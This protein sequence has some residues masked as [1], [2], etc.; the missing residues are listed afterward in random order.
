MRIRFMT[1]T[2]LVALATATASGA[3]AAPA[4]PMPAPMATMPGVYVQVYGGAALAGTWTYG[5]PDPYP[6]GVDD[7]ALGSAFGA[8]VG[9]PV[10]P[11][12][13]SIE[14]DFFHTARTGDTI[15]P[16]TTTSLMVDGK[17][18]FHLSDAF[19][20]YGGAGI[21]GV[22]LGYD[23]GPTEN[24]NGW[25]LGYQVMVGASAKVADNI[26]LFAEFRHQDT[27]GQVTVPSVNAGDTYTGRAPV[28]AILFG[29]K[30][31]M[32]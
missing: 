9:M 20:V 3:Y 26:N 23:Y 15:Y 4:R 16:V 12:G 21:G 24:Y 13:F 11:E 31:G 14:G 2:A 27:F 18:T 17:Y 32:P 25:G 6:G 28:N 1:A 7:V 10:G 8:S 30:F 5:N 29:I 22:D 19:D